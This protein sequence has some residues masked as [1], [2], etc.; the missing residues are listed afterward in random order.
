MLEYMPLTRLNK[1]VL[2]TSGTT[3]KRRKSDSQIKII[4]TP[5]SLGKS[6]DENMIDLDDGLEN[7]Y[8]EHV[9]QKVTVNHTQEP[10][11]KSDPYSSVSKAIYD[12]LG[13][14]A[15]AIEING[16]KSTQENQELWRNI[17]SVLTNQQK[18]LEFSLDQIN[19]QLKERID[20]GMGQ[21]IDHLN[22]SRD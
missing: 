8:D 16:S 21:I 18:L 15:S 12:G 5:K 13:K 10:H 22:S 3:N 4:K 7:D 14:I 2:Q 11:S 19:S 1:R 6:L 17:Q 9:E 20:S